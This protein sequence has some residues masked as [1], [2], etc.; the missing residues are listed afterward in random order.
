MFTIFITRRYHKNDSTFGYDNSSSQHVDDKK[1]N[2]LVLCEGG[3]EGLDDAAIKVF[4][5]DENTIDAIHYR[6]NINTIY[7]YILLIRYFRCP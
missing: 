5:V 6:F 3:T 1:K 7:Y 4:S 2:I